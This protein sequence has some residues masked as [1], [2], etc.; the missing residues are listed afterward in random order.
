MKVEIDPSAGFCFGVTQ[1]I[2][3]AEE[4]LNMDFVCSLGEIVH[5]PEEV[6]R[7][8]KMGMQTISNDDIKSIKGKKVLIR[9][10]GEPPGTFNLLNKNDIQIIDAT[11]P[12]VSKL[13]Q[14]IKRS[15]E[16]AQR[17]N[18]QVLIY[19][20]KDHAEVIGLVGHSGN[21]ALVMEKEDDL[22]SVDFTRPMELYVQTTMTPEGLDKLTNSIKLKI[23]A[24]KGN[25]DEL[26][27]VYNTICRQVSGREKSLR[28]FARLYDIILFVSGKNSSN[29]NRLFTYCKEENPNSYF[30]SHPSEIDNTWIDSVKSIGISGAT[31][32]PAWLLE[33]VK[34]DLE[35]RIPTQCR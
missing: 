20:K 31:S 17:W 2:E 14:R 34:N 22:D 11:C 6:N 16:H 1:A 15:S 27:R 5:N 3:K 26:L 4:E 19:G 7:L 25:P 23:L 35:T 18:S 8:E 12:I 29:G 13:Q 33:Q 32:T 21:F 24:L 10:H 30:I 9:T 28:A